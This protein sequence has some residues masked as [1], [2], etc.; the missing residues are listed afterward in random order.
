MKKNMNM[1]Q[2]LAIFSVS[3]IFLLFVATHI[4]TRFGLLGLGITEIGLLVIALIGC[5][6]LKS[7]WKETFPLKM[8]QFKAFIGS[9]FI[10]ISVFCFSIGLS[11]T[12]LYVFPDM[13][14]KNKILTD[15]FSEGGLVLFLTSSLLPGICEETLFRG[16]IQTTLRRTKNTVV[17]VIIMGILF[18]LFHLDIYRFLPTMVLGMG[19]T[20][21]MDKTRNLLYPI[22]FHALN[23]LVGI[24]PVLLRKPMVITT[25]LSMNTIKL[26]GT[27]FVCFSVGLLFLCLGIRRMNDKNTAM[28]VDN[29]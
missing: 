3:I 5:L 11:E 4:Q 18:G 25:E 2:G 9:V 15:F 23:N 24:L 13:S 27:L 14:E 7:G 17:V 19:F 26:I 28:S 8:V 10:F 29:C 1:L 12:L 16:T 21:I 22:F 6:F 20:Y